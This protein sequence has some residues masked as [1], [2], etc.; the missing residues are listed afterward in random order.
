M[1]SFSKQLSL[2]RG[3][4]IRDFED[5]CAKTQ[6]RKIK[7]LFDKTGNEIISVAAGFSLMKLGKRD[8]AAVVKDLFQKPPARGSTIKEAL[9]KSPDEALSMVIT[10]N[11][12]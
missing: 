7:L 3:R 12:R 10:N 8:S 9:K 1:P 5:W 11:L 6:K 4:S 2:K